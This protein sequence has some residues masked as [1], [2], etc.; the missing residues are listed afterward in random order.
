ML[1]GRGVVLRELGR[2]D[3]VVA[4]VALALGF[5]LVGLVLI[6]AFPLVSLISGVW[7]TLRHLCQTT[8]RKV[9]A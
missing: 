8:S 1:S 9:T 3:A 5:S 4:L 2:L 7:R 6:V